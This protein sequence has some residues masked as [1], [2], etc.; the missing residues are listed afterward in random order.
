[1]AANPPT[2]DHPAF[3]IVREKFPGKKFRGTEFRAQSTLIVEPG[4]LHE[5]LAFLRDEPRLAYNFLSDVLGIDYLNYPA[6]QPGRFAVVYNLISHS[7]DDRFFVKTFVSPSLPTDGTAD[8]PALYID[9]VCDLWPGAEWPEREVFDMFG[10][11]F[12]NHPDLRRILTW[13]EF[14]AHPLRKDY[15]LRGRGEREQ[16]GVIDRTSA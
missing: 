9:S 14:P 12:R 16:Y 2:L 13:E 3:R 1:L 10:I 8:D 15:P 5:V 4:D 6:P 11:R 7:R